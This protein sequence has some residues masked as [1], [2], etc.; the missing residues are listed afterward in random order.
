V[1]ERPAEQK[2]D[3]KERKHATTAVAALRKWLHEEMR[4]GEVYTVDQS[5]LTA[6]FTPSHVTTPKT[7]GMGNNQIVDVQSFL[8]PI[9]GY[10]EKNLSSVGLQLIPDQMMLDSSGQDRLKHMNLALA[11]QKP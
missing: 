5:L 8:P 11:S 1:R 9:I 3:S 7:D 2:T 6:T 10:M 4:T